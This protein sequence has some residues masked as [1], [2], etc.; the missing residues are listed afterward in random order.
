MQS[1]HYIIMH[2]EK[3]DLFTKYLVLFLNLLV[4]PSLGPKPKLFDVL[5]DMRCVTSLV[6]TPY[7]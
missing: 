6:S 4:V 1:V 7:A 3:Q 5:E 2:K